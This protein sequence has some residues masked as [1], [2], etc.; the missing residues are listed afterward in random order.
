MGR[1][2]GSVALVTG[3]S[4]GIGEAMC[5]ELAQRGAAVVLAAR[6]AERIE[7]VAE[8]IR[9]AGGRAVAVA[10]DV[11]VD[12]DP[13]RCVERAIEA[14]GRLDWVV[15]NAGYGVGGPFEKLSLDDYR[16]QLETNLYG[17]L[18]T[19]KASLEALRAS[20]GCLA[21]VGSVN[22]FLALPTVSAYC[23]SKFAVRA[24]ARSLRHELR[25][26]GVAVTLLAP[27]FVESE[28]RKVDNQG[29]YR[30]E[31]R[32]TVPGWLKMPADV[33]ARKMVN[34]TVRRRRVAVV[35]LHGK[36]FVWIER[37]APWLAAWLVDRTAVSWRRPKTP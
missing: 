1:L 12:G 2:D 30:E 33:A 37:H 10:C 15:A 24:L 17:V 18:R 13:E 14:Y 35:T 20:R 31:W 22:S 26:D 7:A 36:L 28:I 29:R 8:R 11:T 16:R 4:S 23:V 19:A 25:P 9:S 21:I 5:I 32:D 34:A 3:A 6:R 27:G